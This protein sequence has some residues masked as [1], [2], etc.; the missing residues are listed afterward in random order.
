MTAMMVT[1][2]ITTMMM[3]MVMKV[4]IALMTNMVGFIPLILWF[5]ALQ[6]TIEMMAMTTMMLV[7][8][9]MR[10]KKAMTRITKKTSVMKS[11]P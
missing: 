1:M 4:E 11:Q 5:M 6:T 9:T 3:M 7:K 10:R 2:T 8:M